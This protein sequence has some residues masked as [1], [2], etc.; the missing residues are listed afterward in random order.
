MALKVG[1][2]YRF[3]DYRDWQRSGDCKHPGCLNDCFYMPCTV[4][5]LYSQPEYPSLADVRFDHDGHE[6]GGHFTEY[7]KPL[8][9]RGF[10]RD[11]ER[12]NYDA[13]I[14]NHVAWGSWE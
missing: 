13:G 3:F 9:G 1:G 7:V 12:E 10:L 6:S 14:R 8:D 4:L 2:R 5:R 11:E